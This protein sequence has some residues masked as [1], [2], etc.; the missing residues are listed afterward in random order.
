MFR[1][2]EVISEFGI[3]ISF[4]ESLLEKAGNKT[5]IVYS[6]PVLQ[7][8][9][10]VV[11]YLSRYCNRIGLNPNQLSYNVGDR[12]TMSYKGYRS[13]GTLRMCC[14]AGELL[15]RLLLHVLPKGL[16]RIRYYGFLANAVRVKAIAEIR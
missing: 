9:T 13:N 4:I 16:I 12:I 10:A 3:R 15:R 8:P 2:Y 7:E 11:G 14:N 6:K 1:D 5:W